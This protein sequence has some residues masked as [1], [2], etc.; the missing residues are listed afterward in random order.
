MGSCM[1]RLWQRPLLLPG[2]NDDE[3]WAT[4]VKRSVCFDGVYGT[5]A[6]TRY[7]QDILVGPVSQNHSRILHCQWPEKSQSL[8]QVVAMTDNACQWMASHTVAIF[9]VI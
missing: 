5:I 2:K 1:L 7:D 6:P 8:I 9:Y 3:E 4:F